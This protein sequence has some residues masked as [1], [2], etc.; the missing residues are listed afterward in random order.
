MFPSQAGT[1]PYADIC[2]VLTIARRRVIAPVVCTAQR[3]WVSPCQRRRELTILDGRRWNEICQCGAR[4]SSKAEQTLSVVQAVAE[5]PGLPR[6]GA[7]AFG[8]EPGI[9][10]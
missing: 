10:E 1:W 8:N 3:F 2:P 6:E 4:L 7:D 9:S 5:K